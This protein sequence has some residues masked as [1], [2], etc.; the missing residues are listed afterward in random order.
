MK[1]CNSCKGEYGNTPHLPDID[2]AN[3]NLRCA[4]VEEEYMSFL[5]HRFFRINT[6]CYSHSSTLNKTFNDR[7]INLVQ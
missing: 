5:V 6:R 7:V 2:A 1:N 4:V 3:C